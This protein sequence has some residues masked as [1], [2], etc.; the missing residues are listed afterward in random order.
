LEPFSRQLS[1]AFVYGSI[2]KGQAN[3]SQWHGSPADR[4]RP[5]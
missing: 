4:R 5:V 3:A 1:W 2:A